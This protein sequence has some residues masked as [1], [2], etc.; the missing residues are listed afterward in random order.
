MPLTIPFHSTVQFNSQFIQDEPIILMDVADTA[1]LGGVVL[2]YCSFPLI[3]IFDTPLTYGVLSTGI[4]Y[5]WALSGH[6][7]SDE[8]GAAVRASLAMD[9]ADQS[10]TDYF[11]GLSVDNSITLKLILASA[12]DEII[13]TFANLHITQV[14]NN[15]EGQLQLTIERDFKVMGGNTT[16]E[17]WPSGRQTIDQAPG[18][19]RQ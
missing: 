1:S 3:R 6:I 10:L 5:T 9:N 11:I 16:V 13:R 18:L 12:P 17:P 8:E 4:M 15:D 14:V 2:R 19:H 7:P